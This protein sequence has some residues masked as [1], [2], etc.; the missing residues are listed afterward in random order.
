MNSNNKKQN[1][2]QLMVAKKY[3]LSFTGTS[4]KHDWLTA[5]SVGF[6]L[7]IIFSAIYYFEK[8]SIKNSISEDNLV[9]EEKR[10]FNI[11]KAEKLLKDFEVR[12]GFVDQSL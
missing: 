8:I 2:D 4:P 3:K 7:I 9:R 10:H 5:L 1:I 12:K 6:I 11:T